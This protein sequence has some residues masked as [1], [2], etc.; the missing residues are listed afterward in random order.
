MRIY[1]VIIGLISDIVK[2][3]FKTVIFFGLFQFL[4]K[5]SLFLYRR[6]VIVQPQDKKILI[7]QL[8]NVGD[9]VCST[10]VFKH[11][12]NAFPGCEIVLLAHR[13]VRGLCESFFDRVIYINRNKFLWNIFY[14][15]GVLKNI[16]QE[17]FSRVIYHSTNQL[18]FVEYFGIVSNISAKEIIGYEGEKI[19]FDAAVNTVYNR[20]LI[21]VLFPMYRRA[22]STCVSSIDSCA[23][24]TVPITS[25]FKHLISFYETVTHKEELDYSTHIK[26]I[27]SYTIPQTP[28]V[29]LGCGAA[30]MYR[31]WPVDRFL[32]VIHH[33]YKKGCTVILIG[34]GEQEL[35]LSQ[36]I[37]QKAPFVQNHVNKTSLLDVCALIQG[38]CM[39][40]SNET[41]FVHLAIA[42]RV[43]TVCVV[44]GGHIG[45]CSL[46]GYPSYTMWV[47]DAHA[48]CLGDNW[49]CGWGVSTASPCVASIAST[50][51][52]ARVD[53]LL[54]H[55]TSHIPSSIL[56][57][58][59]YER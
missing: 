49:L 33:I 23:P 10:S 30:V 2:I 52:C 56:F 39:C 1:N 24:R 55:T 28:Y 32:E 46:Y 15:V 37:V 36:Y 40:I 35:A 42:L 31:Q 41:S 50:D 26:I 6:F 25:I 34:S 9:V 5:V 44:G 45:R 19:F 20:Y 11:Y 4:R 57:S 53:E 18:S 12:R 29:V 14:S 59:T 51:V 7:I 54:S 16:H 8:D 13:S 22:L 58:T 3:V 38:A 47:Y 21:S 43:P 27:S 17:G 48:S